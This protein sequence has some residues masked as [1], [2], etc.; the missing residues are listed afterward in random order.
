MSEMGEYWRDVKKHYSDLKEKEGMNCPG[1]N[2]KEPKR[3]PTV[4][5]FGQK[6]KVCGY[7]RPL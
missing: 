7:T 3:I 4:L 6:C 1:C 2:I 5:L